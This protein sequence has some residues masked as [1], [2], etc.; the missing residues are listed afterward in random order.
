MLPGLLLF[1]VKLFPVK[2]LAL[3]AIAHGHALWGISVILLA[4]VL[5]A[6]IVARWRARKR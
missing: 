3:L 2:L 6:A 5:G 4:K 1:P